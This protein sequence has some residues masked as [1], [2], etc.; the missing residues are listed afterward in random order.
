MVNI[1]TFALCS[2]VLL[3]ACGQTGPLMLT[4]EGGG[5]NANEESS[6]ADIAT[7]PKPSPQTNTNTATTS[8]AE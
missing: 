1:R 2:A 8:P 5:I 6:G 3:G 4:G 7:N